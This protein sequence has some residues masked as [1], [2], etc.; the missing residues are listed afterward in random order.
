MPVVTIINNF[1][2]VLLIPGL[3]AI[4]LSLVLFTRH[5][6]QPANRYLAI[7]VLS[8]GLTVIHQ[9]LIDSNYI[10]YVT[11]LIGSIL[12][13]EFIFPPSLYL[14]IFYITQAPKAPHQIYKHFIPA[15]IAALMLVPFYILEFNIKLEILQNNFSAHLLPEPFHSIFPFFVIGSGIQFVIYFFLYFKLLRSHSKNISLNWLRYFLIFMLL[16]WVVMLL[17]SQIYPSL[18]HDQW[19]YLFS[20]IA[21]IYIAVMGILQ[22]NNGAD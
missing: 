20:A 22:A 8:I 9:F 15:A 3:L 18:I 5:Y 17:L 19:L 11:N 21:V 2:L 16:F 1:S 6:N 12:A 10:R 14:Y 13:L 7:F 4:I